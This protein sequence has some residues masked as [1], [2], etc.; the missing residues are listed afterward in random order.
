MESSPAPHVRG[1][2]GTERR[3]HRRRRGPSHCGPTSPGIRKHPW[4]HVPAFWVLTGQLES[5]EAGL[6]ADSSKP[7]CPNSHERTKRASHQLP[8]GRRGVGGGAE[9]GAG[10]ATRGDLVQ[11]GAAR[12]CADGGSIAGGSFLIIH[13][14]SVVHPEQYTVPSF[15]N[16]YD[17][18]PLSHPQF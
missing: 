8:F 12:A 15:L 3:R 11:A 1:G 18:E 17:T 7:K 16:L 14:S 5:A 13:G 4:K 6:C 9:C 2:I 10:K